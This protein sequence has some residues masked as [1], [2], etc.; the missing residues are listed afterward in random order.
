MSNLYRTF[1]KNKKSLDDDSTLQEIC[2]KFKT[3]FAIYRDLNN[4]KLTLDKF[5]V[6]STRLLGDSFRSSVESTVNYEFQKSNTFSKDFLFKT[7][8]PQKLSILYDEYKDSCISLANKN[9]VL[10]KIPRDD[11]DTLINSFRD[12]LT[13]L[14]IRKPFFQSFLQLLQS[15][16]NH[17]STDSLYKSFSI[18]I[19]E[20]QQRPDCF[21]N[22]SVYDKVARNIIILSNPLTKHTDFLPKISGTSCSPTDDSSHPTDDS[23]PDS[24]DSFLLNNSE[25][26]HA[27]LSKSHYSSD[28]DK[29]ENSTKG[30][31][32][33]FWLDSD[34]D[35]KEFWLDSEQDKEFWLD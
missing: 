5:F 30:E 26:L 9:I 20:L 33:E 16:K 15:T 3:L 11:I 27:D 13:E 31:D 8:I 34:S 14:G 19:T 29:D 17:P 10:H 2:G 21:L 28:S 1:T 18:L 23:S 12:L 24:L 35:V 32:K 25:L 4:N 22:P 6:L 7:I